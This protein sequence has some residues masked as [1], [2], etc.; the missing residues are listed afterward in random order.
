MAEREGQDI[1]ELIG[2]KDLK[3]L[4]AEGKVVDDRTETAEIVCANLRDAL[5]QKAAMAV[6]CDGPPG[7]GKSGLAD[8]I[9]DKVVGEGILPEED[10]FRLDLD[11]FLGTERG[12]PARESLTDNAISFWGGYIQYEEGK[13]VLREAIDL[14]GRGKEGEIHI[15]RAY[16][17][18][19]GGK[20]SPH[21]L[22]PKP[23][24]R[25][26]LIDGVG[27]IGNLAEPNSLPS[28]LRPYSVMTHVRGKEGV[29]Q[30][31][32]RDMLNGRDGITF[33]ELYEIRRAE[34]G[35]LVPMLSGSVE[36]ADR[37]YRRFPKRKD[38]RNG[39]VKKDI[40]IRSG[41]TKAIRTVQEVLAN[42][43]PDFLESIFPGEMPKEFRKGKQK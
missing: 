27:A 39:L 14:V 41:H 8:K 4:K 30:A 22:T 34:Y 6:C 20:F 24:T 19:S 5:S 15:P 11:L 29:F 12:T 31:T 35:Y 13:R 40:E 36:R 23:S 16:S 32:L 1:P 3:A 38:F 28:W 10:I 33:E 9:K 37:I 2:K 17:R 18:E 42:V 21:K 7:S 43:E 26:F 25:L